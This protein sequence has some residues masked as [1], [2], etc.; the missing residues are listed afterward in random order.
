MT[1]LSMSFGQRV[2][3]GRELTLA[4][5]IYRDLRKAIVRGEIRPNQR[6][7]EAQLGIEMKVSRTP[8]REVLQRLANDGLVISL[9][10]RGWQVHEHTAGEI[11]EIFESRAALESYAARLAAARVTPEQLEVI[12]R[13][14]GERGSG[15]MGNARHDLVEL[16]DRFHDSVTDAGG[17]TLLAELVRR[18][19]LYHF[20][21]QLAALYSKK[22]LAQSHTEH[23][24]L[25]RALRDHDPDAAADAVRRHVESAL[26]TVRILRTSPAYAED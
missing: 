10:R 2:D 3:D 20:N 6:I 16:N 1:R 17:N 18:S 5:V 9:R 13:T 7:T 24:Q 4:D 21:Y 25:V 14:L 11:R 22:A 12:Q 23:Q 19:R 26:E 15:M 8:I